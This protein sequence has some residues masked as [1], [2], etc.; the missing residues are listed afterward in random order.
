MGLYDYVDGWLGALLRFGNSDTLAQIA[1]DGPARLWE[2]WTTDGSVAQGISFAQTAAATVSAAFVFVIAISVIKRKAL[3][4]PKPSEDTGADEATATATVPTGGALRERWNEIRSH[5]D[6]SREA[7]W[8]V[9]VL[10][11]DKL[12]DDSLARAGFPGD[13]FGDRLTNIQPGTLLALDGLWWAHRIRNRLAHETDYFLR[14]TEARTAV[15]YYEQA[16]AELQLI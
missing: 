11:A 10:E 3:T 14:Y 9:A 13:S 16:L 6:S 7:D 12:V 8:K 4:A 5:L 2:F 1:N 15:G